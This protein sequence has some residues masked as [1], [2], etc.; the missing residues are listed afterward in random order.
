MGPTGIWRQHLWDQI[1]DLNKGGFLVHRNLTESKDEPVRSILT[2]WPA[3]SQSLHH[4]ESA[5]RKR[6]AVPADA[7]SSPG[8]FIAPP[9]CR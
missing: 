8:A 9:C 3:T 2:S 5:R 1:G 4:T 6:Q 7:A